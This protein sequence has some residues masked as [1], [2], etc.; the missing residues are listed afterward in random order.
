MRAVAPDR[1]LRLAQ[2]AQL[3]GDGPS[4]AQLTVVICLDHASITGGQ[5]KVAIDSAIGLKRAGARPIVFAA[6]GP[7]DPRLEAAGVEVVCLGQQD[8]LGHSSR[9]AAALQGIWNVRAAVALGKLLAEA[10]RDRTVVHVHGWAKA[11][12]PSIVAPLRAAGLPALYTLHE[13]FLFC[14]NGGFYNYQRNAVCTLKPR[15]LRCLATHCDSRNYAHKLWR[16]GRLQAGRV[17]LRMAEAF[18]DYVCISDHQA[19]IVQSQLP[20]GARL[21]RL[22]N[23]VDAEKLGP[24]AEPASGDLIYVG[25]LSPEKGAAL[26]A[27]A[28]TRV[29][30]IPTLI[31]DGPQADEL[32]R[33]FPQA[34][35]LG[36]LPT[37]ETRKRM[38]AARALI[39]PSRWYETNG[40]VAFE[41][42]AMGTPVIVSDVCA[43]REAVEDGVTGL[44][45]KNG[46]V[47]ALADALERIRDDALVARMSR[48]AYDDYWRAPL[49]LEAHVERLLTIY[50]DLASP[51]R[52]A[53]VGVAP[54]A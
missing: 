35:F 30:V 46:S 23:P 2:A 47:G 19:Q 31:G 9:A 43:A 10:P 22:S 15:S 49:T 29:G 52:P 7:V 54:A 5:A 53:E 41:A 16:F 18:S 21:H 40:L 32:K 3:G 11:L 33:R 1:D 6:A 44:W 36:W 50:A 38:R 24:K 45:F 8:L 26:F 37:H 28:A 39:F 20:P 13:Y 14:P 4:A 27:E 51:R 48:A 34:R 42:K 25:R 17:W 12:S